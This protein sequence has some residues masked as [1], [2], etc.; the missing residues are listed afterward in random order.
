[1]YFSCFMYVATMLNPMLKVVHD[2]DPHT[3]TMF[4]M[5]SSLAFL[6]A[7]PLAFVLRSKQILQRRVIIYG[8]L[9]LMG[10]GMIMRTGDF[11]EF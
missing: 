4:Y 5:V 8:A 11:R 3:S 1:M 6:L 2:L 10:L 9:V 7:T